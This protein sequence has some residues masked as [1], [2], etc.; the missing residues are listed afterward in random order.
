MI[1]NPVKSLSMASSPRMSLERDFMIHNPV[2]SLSMAPSPRMSLEKSIS[3]GSSRA[4]S[5]ST[6]RNVTDNLLAD[7][8]A[9]PTVPPVQASEVSIHR[10]ASLN[11]PEIPVLLLGTIAS[12]VNGLI[13]PVYALLLSEVIKTF[14]KPPNELRT[15]S[16]FWALIFMA[17]GLASLL[18][19]PAETYLF[20]V[21]GC[22]L[23]QRV[24]SMCFQKVI[25]MEVGW[26]DEPEH[27]SG[28]LGARLSADAATLRALVG[29]ALSK[30]VQSIVSAIAG[31]VIDFIASWQLA[32][33]VLTLFR[34]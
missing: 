33:I 32:L 3:R 31:L 6:G 21:A 13:L 7:A 23:I 8:K 12:V 34:S 15:D 20:S 14:Y 27:S 19:Y 26:F 5:I 25:H 16:R 24:R 18:A 11:T 28:S 22:K 2:K 9:P 17:L 4:G 1:H 10:L 30:I 29:D